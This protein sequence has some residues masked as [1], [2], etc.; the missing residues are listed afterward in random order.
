MTRRATWS[1]TIRGFVGIG[2][3]VVTTKNNSD[4]ADYLI[5]LHKARSRVR[6]GYEV[7]DFSDEIRIW[8]VHPTTGARRTL[9][10]LQHE[11]YSS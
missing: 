5:A 6:Y 11:G 3:E 4:L 1:I 10:N 9:L 2:T 8:T 7:D